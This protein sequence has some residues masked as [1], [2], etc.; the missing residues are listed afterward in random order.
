M[1]ERDTVARAEKSSEKSFACLVDE[2][3][4]GP[5]V[6]RLCWKMKVLQANRCRESRPGLMKAGIHLS[7]RGVQ[8]P[9]EGCCV[10]VLIFGLKT[11]FGSDIHNE[12]GPSDQTVT[13]HS[14]IVFI[15]SF[16]TNTLSRVAI[17]TF[18]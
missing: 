4:S 7:S 9:F 5:I 1:G 3:Q 11:E 15:R 16:N 13:Y 10:E 12:V 14:V 18:R 6:A 2:L 8:D 17:Y